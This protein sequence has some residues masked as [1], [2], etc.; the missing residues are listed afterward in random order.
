QCLALAPRCLPVPRRR[1]A[2]G[3]RAAPRRE[4][5]ASTDAEA[6]LALVEEIASGLALFGLQRLVA[7][8]A[9]AVALSGVQRHAIARPDLAQPLHLHD[10]PDVVRGDD[11]R[12]SRLVGDR[13]PLGVTR[14]RSLRLLVRDGVENHEA[15]DEAELPDV[16]DAQRA[17]AH[18]AAAG[19][20][21]V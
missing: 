15:T 12:M 18:N 21:L 13:A 14:D 9:P 16:L 4:V 2:H 10:A 20:V 19:A 6:G 3:Q 7:V 11:A 8:V 5:L 1:V 17:H